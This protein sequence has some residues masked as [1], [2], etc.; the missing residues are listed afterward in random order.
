MT[1]TLAGL[2]LVLIA[3]ACGGSRGAPDGGGAGG[4]GS[5]G[6]TNRGGTG[7]DAQRGGRGGIGGA[8]G[9]TGGDAQRGGSGGAIAGAGGVAGVGGDRAPIPL[10][11]TGTYGPWAI[12]VNATH[13]YWTDRKTAAVMKVPIA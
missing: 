2:G 12:A 3:A 4:G 8:G 13:V 6:N 1:R 9:G 7:G 11:S 10:S 5:G